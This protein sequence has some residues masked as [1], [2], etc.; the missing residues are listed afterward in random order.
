MGAVRVNQG[1]KVWTGQLKNGLNLNIKLCKASS[2]LCKAKQKVQSFFITTSN[3][4]HIVNMF[5]IVFSKCFYT[6]KFLDI[7]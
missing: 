7:F 6:F 3:L 5:Y 2:K 1:V 4:F